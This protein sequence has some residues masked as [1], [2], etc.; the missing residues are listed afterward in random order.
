MKLVFRATC[1]IRMTGSAVAAFRYLEINALGV[2]GLA[3]GGQVQVGEQELVG[4]A[5]GQVE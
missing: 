5:V 2:I 3:R 1:F 4:S